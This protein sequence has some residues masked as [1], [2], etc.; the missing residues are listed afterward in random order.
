M[1][2]QVQDAGNHH[3]VCGASR[4]HV[5]EGIRDEWVQP[6]IELDTALPKGVLDVFCIEAQGQRRLDHLG[7]AGGEV[8]SSIPQHCVCVLEHFKCRLQPPALHQPPEHLVVHSRGVV[9]V[10]AGVVPICTADGPP[11]QGRVIHVAQGHGGALHGVKAQLAVRGAPELVLTP[12]P[13]HVAEG[14]IHTAGHTGVEESA[15]CGGDPVAQLVEGDVDGGQGVE[16]GVTITVCHGST[17]PEGVGVVAPVVRPGC[18]GPGGEPAV[19]HV[20]GAHQLQSLGAVHV[21]VRHGGDTSIDGVGE[22]RGAVVAEG[23]GGACA[24]RHVLAVHGLDPRVLQRAG[25]AGLGDVQ[26]GLVVGSVV[27]G[28]VKED[29]P[30]LGVAALAIRQNTSQGLLAVQNV[31]RVVISSAHHHQ[32][33]RHRLAAACRAVHEHDDIGQV[34]ICR[35]KRHKVRVLRQCP[36]DQVW[37]ACHLH[38]LHATQ[39]HRPDCSQQ[40]LLSGDVGPDVVEGSVQVIAKHRAHRNAI[41][42]DAVVA[43]IHIQHHMAAKHRHAPHL[44]LELDLLH[45][46][47]AC[48]LLGLLLLLE[49]SPLQAQG[50]RGV[51]SAALSL[52]GLQQIFNIVQGHLDAGLALCLSVDDHSTQQHQHGQA[53]KCWENGGRA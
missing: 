25:G 24:G 50:I 23:S 44:L 51:A 35:P 26:L 28:A 10:H 6:R 5:G 9:D 8:L 2:R 16:A 19:D 45:V 14:L 40:G 49:G 13:A 3:G 33:H 37:P 27:G 18:D 31:S 15:V 20:V 12:L 48:F 34:R 1:C 36:D 47:P 46:P 11:I 17:I 39:P 43:L 53:Q 38:L 30:G 22:A 41:W 4:N 32:G 42:I 29:G 52:V 21:Y 7:G